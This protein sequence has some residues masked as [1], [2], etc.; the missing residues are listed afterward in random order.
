MS[1]WLRR[2]TGRGGLEELGPLIPEHSPCA[3]LGTEPFRCKF[4]SPSIHPLVRLIITSFS[5]DKAVTEGK[6]HPEAA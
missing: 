4:I 1:S 5:Q 3:T 6:G 2:W